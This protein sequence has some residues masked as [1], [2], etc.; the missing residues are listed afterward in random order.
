MDAEDLRQRVVEVESR[1][2]FQEQALVDLSDALAQLRAELE[3]RGRLLDAALSD[4]KQL[5]TL[6]YAEPG[7]EPPPPH[8]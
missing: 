2:A 7:S 8:Y 1:L 5:R 6:L 3:R 4:L